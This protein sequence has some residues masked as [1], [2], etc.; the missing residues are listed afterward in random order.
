MGLGSTIGLSGDPWEGHTLKTNDTKNW[1]WINT[2]SHSSDDDWRQRFAALRES[3]IQAILPEV[4]NN[5]TAFWDSQHLP[6][7][8]HWLEQLIPLAQ[9]AGLEVHAWIHCMTCNI[10]EIMENHPEWYDVN[11]NRESAVDKPAYVSY[12]R[13]LCPSR[14]GVQDFLRQRVS[15]LAA[16][17]G[18]DGIHLDYIRFPDVIL[19]EALQPKYDIVQDRE[20]P[21]YDYCYC[22]VCRADFKKASGIDPLSDLEDPSTSEEWRQFRYNR[23]SALVNDHL[24]PAGRTGGKQMTAAVFPNWQHVRQE[25]HVWQLDAVLP[26]LYNSFYNEDAAWVGQQCV[27]GIARMKEKGVPKSLYSGLFVPGL[28]PAELAEAVQTS[29]DGGAAGVSLFALGSMSEEHWKAFNKAR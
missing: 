7:G 15:E 26:M 28:K 12:Y 2:D 10:P 27:A 25:W 16:I 6:V 19:A 1:T 17:E 24:I 8:D 18:L 3:G 4:F 22:D 21:E 29:R 5:R 9:E 13:F 11:G 14:P 20:Y 23:I